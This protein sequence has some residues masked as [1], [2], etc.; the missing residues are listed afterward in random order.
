MTPGTLDYPKDPHQR[1]HGPDGYTMYE[2]Y[3]PW[4]RDEFAFQCVYCLI[5]ERASREGHKVFGVDH[6]IPQ[7]ANPAL[8]SDYDNLVYSCN[9]CN[10]ARGTQSGVLDPCKSAYSDHMR[11][12]ADGF[13]EGLTKPGKVHIEVL[14]LNEPDLVEFRVEWMEKVRLLLSPTCNPRWYRLE[15]HRLRYP[16]KLPDLSSLK[17]PQNSRPEGVRQSHYARLLAGELPEM[18]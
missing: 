2:S 14:D 16:G 4:L 10:S 5:R 17:P 18:Y 15:S 7:T 12:R 8:V 3:K 11:V 6:I 13:V 9:R 1:R